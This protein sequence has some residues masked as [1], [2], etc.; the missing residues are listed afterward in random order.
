MAKEL[1]PDR[2]QEKLKTAFEY[3]VDS[4][5]VIIRKLDEKVK[6]ASEE[7]SLIKRQDL[8]LQVVV[9]AISLYSPEVANQYLDD[10]KIEKLV[11]LLK[12]N[13]KYTIDLL[14]KEKDIYEKLVAKNEAMIKSFPISFDG[15]VDHITVKV[16]AKAYKNAVEIALTEISVGDQQIPR[17][18]YGKK[19]LKKVKEKLNKPFYDEDTEEKV[20]I[21]TDTILE[22]K[23]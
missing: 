3:Q 1:I 11:G 6:L 21:S 20:E 19:F 2:P 8:R 10:T 15:V 23:N 12:E 5:A 9:A 7:P 18:K 16:Q 4:A 13:K 14:P 17:K 22:M